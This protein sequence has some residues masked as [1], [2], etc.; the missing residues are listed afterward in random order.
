MSST[1][2]RKPGL[3][4]IERLARAAEEIRRPPWR[5]REGTTTVVDREGRYITS[6]EHPE[7]ALYLAEVHPA[8]VL[9]L[10]R[11]L[12]VAEARLALRPE[13]FR[14]LET[15][16]SVVEDLL[17]LLAAAAPLGWLQM[18]GDEK[19]ISQQAERELREALLAEPIGDLSGLNL[20]R[21]VQLLRAHPSLQEVR[22]G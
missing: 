7:L 10:V 2:E 13:T 9:E 1:T 20:A 14:L 3:D 4:L 18:A 11:Q 5:K 19:P 15:K 6:Q 21:L 16:A 8:T 12:R 17:S 22:G